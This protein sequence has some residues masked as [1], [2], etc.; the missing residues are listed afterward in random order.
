MEL[1]CSNQ[2]VDFCIITYA[3]RVFRQ[4]ET[5]IFPKGMQSAADNLLHL[6]LVFV[7]LV[8]QGKG[9]EKAHLHLLWQ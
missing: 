6:L 8:Q 1:L 2:H 9:G 5:G 4:R 7:F 3:Q